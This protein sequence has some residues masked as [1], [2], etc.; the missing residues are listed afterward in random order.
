MLKDAKE[1]EKAYQKLG[2]IG[3]SGTVE[4]KGCLKQ[5]KKIKKDHNKD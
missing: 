1:L 4:K 2:K 3:K 5:L